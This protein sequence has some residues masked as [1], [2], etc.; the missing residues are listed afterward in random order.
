MIIQ[1]QLIQS[2]D[3][4][5]AIA[6]IGTFGGDIISRGARMIGDL[7]RNCQH[8]AEIGTLRSYICFRA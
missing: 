7:S 8:V 1:D 2:R 3:Q 4:G 6:V 5:C